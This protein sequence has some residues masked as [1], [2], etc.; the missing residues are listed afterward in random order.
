MP[1]QFYAYEDFEPG[2]EISFGTYA[3]TAAEIREDPVVRESH[4]IG[5]GSHDR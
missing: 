4:D 3:V 5:P 2:M 1:D